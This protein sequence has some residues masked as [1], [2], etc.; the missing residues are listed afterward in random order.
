M[1]ALEFS[2]VNMNELMRI[3]C[4]ILNIGEKMTSV[5]LLMSLLIAC[6]DSEETVEKPKEEIV[7]KKVVKKDPAK[8]Y[9]ALVG[10]GKTSQVSEF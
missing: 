10:L 7:E 9:K 6:G 4:A 2:S 5:V 8:R 1:V 3:F